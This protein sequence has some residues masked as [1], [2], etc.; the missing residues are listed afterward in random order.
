M[1]E[2]KVLDFNNTEQTEHRSSKKGKPNRW[3]ILLLV[4][5]IVFLSLYIIKSEMKMRE[6]QKEK[7]Y[8]EEENA[9]LTR[10]KEE[11]E[12][13]LENINS[14]EYIEYMARKNLNMVKSGELVFILP[15]D[16]GSDSDD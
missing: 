4:V 6:L 2:E 8:Q 5:V 15:E 9:R 7:T 3:L 11:L 12:N 1:E 10:E 16:E 13:E 14:D